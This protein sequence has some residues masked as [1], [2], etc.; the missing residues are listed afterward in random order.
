MKMELSKSP[1]PIGNYPEE[2]RNKIKPY[3]PSLS[4]RVYDWERSPSLNHL[5]QP[6]NLTSRE[7]EL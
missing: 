1:S 6:E 7:E 3:F 2:L 5:A 4:T